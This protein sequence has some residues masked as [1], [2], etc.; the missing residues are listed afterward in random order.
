MIRRR[1]LLQGLCGLATGVLATPRAEAAARPFYGGRARLTLPI[2][3]SRIDPH[4]QNGLSARLVGAALFDGLYA[5]SSG[6][7][8]YPTL[9]SAMPERRGSVLALELRPGLRSASGVRLDARAVAASLERS[10]KRS[11]H[12]RS[13]QKLRA[14]GA[15][16]VELTTTLEPEQLA[17]ELTELQTAIVPPAFDPGRPDC[18]GALRSTGS[19]IQRLARNGWAARG[20]SY[21]D[22]VALTSGDLRA[23]LR[24]FEGLTS[25]VGFLGSG[26]HRSRG[27]ARQFALGPLGWLVLV[28][29]RRLGRFGAPG[30]LDAA[31]S[32]LPRADFAALGVDLAS[33]SA[34][35]GWTGPGVS[36]LVDAK[37]PWLLAIADELARAW[38]TPRA[39]VEPHPLAAGELEARMKE[40]DFDCT[41]H[42]LGT[43]DRLAA[44]RSL[45]ELA[46]LPPPQR[47]QT[48]LSLEDAVRHLPI[49]LVGRLAPRGFY[50]GALADLAA[51]GAFDLGNARFLP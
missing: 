1:Q 4:D 16:V 37:E 11:S 31:L 14:V 15:T 8:V 3:T 51:V 29:G 23:C 25:D 19:G 13:V 45:F 27:S 9:A 43:T 18:T 2:D 24:A 34:G 22:E 42:F 50:N 12:L 28:P 46:R 6:G 35:A 40:G 44:E 32:A 49:A 20:G 26:L 39:R 33:R 38:D 5:R 41:L 47:A 17:L 10:Q 48:A 21:L 7:T 30:V 36:L